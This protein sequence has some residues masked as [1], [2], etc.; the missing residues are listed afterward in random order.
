MA[1]EYRSFAATDS[2]DASDEGVI[3]G[4]AIPYNRVTTIGSLDHGGFREQIAPGSCTKSIREADVVALLNHNSNQPLGRMSAG[5]LKLNST[6]RG[7]EPELTPTDTS[8]ARDLI[9]NVKATV[10]RGWSFG[11]EVIKDDWT[12]DGEPSDEWSGTDRT[13]RE[14][15]LIE[16]SPVTFPAYDQTD[17]STRSAILSEREA[18]ASGSH[19]EN[20]G[21]SVR[22][23]QQP[24]TADS[25][26]RGGDAPGNGAK[27]YGNVTY[28]DPG[29]QKDGKKRYPIDTKAHAVAAWAF[30]NKTANAAAYNSEQLAKVKAAIK[31]ALTKFGVSISEQNENELATEWRE[32]IKAKRSERKAKRTAFKAF[33]ESRAAL[34]CASCG[35]KLT[36]LKCSPPKNLPHNGKLTVPQPDSPNV[37]GT[38]KDGITKAKAQDGPSGSIQSSA[39]PDGEQRAAKASYADIETCG[40]CGATGQYGAYCSNCGKPMNGQTQKGKF[41][42]KCGN[43]LN[44]KN[45]DSHV[46]DERSKVGKQTFDG[47]SGASKRIPQITAILNQALK[48]FAGADIDSLPADVQTAIAL[49]SSASTHSNHI[50]D[51]GGLTPK[52]SISANDAK[53]RSTE[54]KPEETTSENLPDD[55]ALILARLHMISRDIKLGN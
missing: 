32:Q 26:H 46:C 2:V 18:R 55:T 44:D 1:I 48:L 41:C 35:N 10:I 24:A 29:Y 21:T 33:R 14:M 8:Y 45:R 19:A 13:I 31:A 4:L 27:P 49:V 43:K 39:E 25:D 30:V 15:R 54:P 16:V 11:F 37:H 12:R 36:C 52:D 5:N 34:H 23:S 6:P 38:A 9:V 50:S 20:P 42:T 47:P 3:F 53:G 40:D 7:V 51:H 22:G 17:I 28:A